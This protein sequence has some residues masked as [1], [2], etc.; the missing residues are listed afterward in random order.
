MNLICGPIKMI[1]WL[2]DWLVRV[3]A[4]RKQDHK[5]KYHAKTVHFFLYKT[6]TYQ[7][8]YQL[9]TY[10]AY[11]NLL[12]HLHHHM[13]LHHNYHHHHHNHLLQ[14]LQIQGNHNEKQLGN[15]FAQLNG[16][17]NP[18][19]H[20]LGKT[21]KFVWQPDNEHKPLLACILKKIHTLTHCFTYLGSSLKFWECFCLE[22]ILVELSLKDPSKPHLYFCLHARVWLSCFIW[23]HVKTKK[24]TANLLMVSLHTCTLLKIE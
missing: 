7:I 13:I 8:I 11:N 4:Y 2:I 16:L 1:D 19:I 10:L 23:A 6:D 20:R 5:S 18:S 21:L 12:H 17:Q 9:Y 3:G 15:W 14:I 24:I 22:T